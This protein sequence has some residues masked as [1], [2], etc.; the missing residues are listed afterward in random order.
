MKGKREELVGIIE[1]P[2]HRWGCAAGEDSK[3][4][5]RRSVASGG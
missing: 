2:M 1:D 4:L 5:R 3:A